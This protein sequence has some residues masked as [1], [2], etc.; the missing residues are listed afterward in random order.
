MAY[1]TMNIWHDNNLEIVQRHYTA[2]LLVQNRMLYCYE[3]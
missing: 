2:I 3:Q 1:L